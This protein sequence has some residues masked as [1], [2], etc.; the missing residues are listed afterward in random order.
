MQD[1]L[2]EEL[3][4]LLSEEAITT[5]LQPIVNIE[6]RA[7]FGYE[8]LSRGP[9]TAACMEPSCCLKPPSAAA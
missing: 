3:N 7:V 6:K 8:A 4:R 9:R 5:L 1:C 2:N